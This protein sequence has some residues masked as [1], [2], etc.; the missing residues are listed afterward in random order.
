[1]KRY[2]IDL[3]AP[4]ERLTIYEFLIEEDHDLINWLANQFEESGSIPWMTI[5]ED[6]TWREDK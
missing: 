2:K 5:T 1:M 6:E 3:E 4:Y